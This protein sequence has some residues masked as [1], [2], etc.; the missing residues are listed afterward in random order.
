M[1]GHLDRLK[2]GYQQF[3][4][5]DIQAA[6]SDWTEDFTWEGPNAEGLPGSGEHKGKDEAL[7][8]L[9]KAVGAW[10]EFELHPDEFFEQGDTAV[11]LGH[12]KVT[13]GGDTAETPVVHIWRFDGDQPCRLQIL[14]D[15]LQAA[16]MLEVV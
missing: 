10:D 4:Q 2:E 5:G 7:E 14:T 6:S 16:R 3:S 13:K 12:T 8:T 11:V 9:G 15:T 1:A